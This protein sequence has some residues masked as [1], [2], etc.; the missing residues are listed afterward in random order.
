[1][2]DAICTICS[3]NFLAQAR[4]LT[5]S[6]LRHHPGG[7]VYVL[8]VDDISGRFDLLK[9]KF[10]S[11]DVR[12]LRTPG[13]QDMAARYNIME[14]STAVKPFLLQHLFTLGIDRLVYYDPDIYFFHRTDVVWEALG[15]HKI[16]LTPHLL[17]PL[18]PGDLADDVE[19]HVITTGAY[20]LGFLG[21]RRGMEADSLLRWLGHK[22]FK[23][24]YLRLP[25]LFVDQFWADPIPAMFDGVHVLRDPGCNAA[26]WNLAS[27]PIRREQAA[28]RCGD[29]WLKFFHFSGFVPHSPMITAKYP[30]DKL[31]A[32]IPADD[33]RMMVEEYR[34]AL[35]GAGYD[36]CLKWGYD[37]RGHVS[38]LRIPNKT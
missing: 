29:S 5:S 19:R 25:S 20:N 21:L 12:D 10:T 2:I 4:A 17:Q 30:P 18:P 38:S 11:V 31:V 22:T 15:A 27:R 3:R 16:V 14:F 24:G 26:W 13:T 34:K 36:E 7:K 8:F 35:L 33:H 32:L 9:E 28:Y 23:W 1:M 6:Y 37:Y